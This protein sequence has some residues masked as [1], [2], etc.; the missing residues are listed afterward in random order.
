MSTFDGKPVHVPGGHPRALDCAHG[1]RG[2]PGTACP[3][4]GARPPLPDRELTPAEAKSVR[5]RRELDGGA[6]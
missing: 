1:F 2:G 5:I 6:K 3:A 4:C